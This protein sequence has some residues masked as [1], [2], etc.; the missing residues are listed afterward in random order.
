[1]S[2]LA[3]GLRKVAAFEPVDST[4]LS[5]FHRVQ[6]KIF[7]TKLFKTQSDCPFTLSI[8]NRRLVTTSLR[9]RHHGKRQVLS[10]LSPSAS[11]CVSLKDVQLYKVVTGAFYK[12]VIRV[13]SDHQD[14]GDCSAYFLNAVNDC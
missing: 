9:F 2:V 10:S 3:E 13:G 6:M 8:S 4:L 1:M 5:R 12:A 7:Q 14:A 11:S